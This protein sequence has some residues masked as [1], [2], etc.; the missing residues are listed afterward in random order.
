MA[1]RCCLAAGPPEIDSSLYVRVTARTPSNVEIV[2]QA[3]RW[4]HDS[5]S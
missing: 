4:G 1:I 3:V 5:G 2:V